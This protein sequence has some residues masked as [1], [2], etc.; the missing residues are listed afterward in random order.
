MY[1]TAQTLPLLSRIG[2]FNFPIFDFAN[3]TMDR[4]LMVMTHHLVTKT[5][6]MNR[7]ALPMDK[8]LRFIS[9]IEEGYHADLTYHNSIHATDVLHC[10]NYIISLPNITK[11]FTDLEILAL[12]VAAAVHDY[13]HPGVNNNFL[14]ST[15]DRRALLYNDRSVLE[16][17][18]CASAFEVLMRKECNFLGKLDRK[19]FKGVR[20]HIVAM[21]LATDLSQHFSLLTMFKK[22]VV[23]GG[24]FDPL[25]SG[26]DK[27]LLMQMLMKCADV[28]N[29]TKSWPIYC[30]WIKRITEEFFSQGDQEKQHGLPISPFCNRD[31]PSATNPA[32][33]QKS[34][35]EFIVAPLF[36]ALC[37]WQ[38]MPEVQEG[39]ERNRNI[40]G[41]PAKAAAAAAAVA[42]VEVEAKKK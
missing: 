2:E 12:F 34:F 32:S 8:F 25:S 14:I 41:S 19:V 37:E 40:W 21:V 28:S 38:P 29:P 10:I 22:K 4:P 20:D 23:N 36:E 30:E 9:T 33:S 24:G 1:F 39:L 31:A 5:G 16:N 18:H 26:E 35:I 42:A 27:S 3:A 13:D 15:N 7:L 17:H 6:I 11:L